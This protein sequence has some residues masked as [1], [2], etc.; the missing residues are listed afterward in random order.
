M[1]WAAASA[2]QTNMIARGRASCNVRNIKNWICF[3]GSACGPQSIA[4]MGFRLRIPMQWRSIRPDVWLPSLEVIP[5]GN[6]PLASPDEAGK[7][8]RMQ[9][10]AACALLPGGAVVL[11]V[12]RELYCGDLGCSLPRNGDASLWMSSRGSI[13][14]A[15]LQGL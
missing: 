3:D 6:D 9:L 13:G 7:L 10:L 4:I 5:A 11:A 12:A 1:S 8:Y 2:E 14:L 15:K